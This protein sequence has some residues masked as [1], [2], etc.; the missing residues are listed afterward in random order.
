MWL[1]VQTW[2][3]RTSGVLVFTPLA[4]NCL[5]RQLVSMLTSI[6]ISET[7]YKMSK[8]LFIH[9]LFI[10]LALTLTFFLNHY[11]H[12]HHHHLKFLHIAIRLNNHLV[13]V[14]KS[15]CFGSAVSVTKNTAGKRSYILLQVSNG[16]TLT[17][18]G[19]CPRTLV[20]CF[21][22]ISPVIT[23]PVSPAP[24]D[25]KASSYRI[26]CNVNMIGNTVQI[27]YKLNVSP[28]WTF[29]SGDQAGDTAT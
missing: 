3:P 9:I 11:H 2:S 28:I 16:F 7:L 21:T 18:V 8:L 1:A 23:P 22:A 25:M 5:D 17:N 13:R 12:R 15:T 4:H 20:S 6:D 27:S 10:T 24:P 19:I 29:C 14:R 26:T